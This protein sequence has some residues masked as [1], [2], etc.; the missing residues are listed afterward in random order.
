MNI[1]YKPN[2]NKKKLAESCKKLS[3]SVE[4]RKCRQKK[5]KSANKSIITYRKISNLGCLEITIFE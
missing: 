3:H 1:I 2:T 5:K 4:Q